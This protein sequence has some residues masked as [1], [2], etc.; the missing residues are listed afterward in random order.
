MTHFKLICSFQKLDD[1]EEDHKKMFSHLISLER[2]REK[3]QE[4]QKIKN[5]LTERRK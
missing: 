1:E 4:Q 2:K 5:K 3:Q